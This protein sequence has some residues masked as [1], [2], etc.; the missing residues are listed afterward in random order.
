M[1]SGLGLEIDRVINI[2]VD[3]EELVKRLS[4]RRVCHDCSNM[5]SINGVRTGDPVAEGKCPVCGGALFQR[6]DDERDVIMRRLHIYQNQTKPLVDYYSGRKL[7]AN[8][9]GSG[10]EEEIAE[11]IISIL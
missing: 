1:L 3:D 7:L 2:D 4:G 10:S 11:R 8:V 5:C 6:K 9:D